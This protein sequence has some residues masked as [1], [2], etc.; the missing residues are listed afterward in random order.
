LQIGAAVVAVGLARGQTPGGKAPATVGK[1]SPNRPGRLSPREAVQDLVRREKLDQ[2][3]RGPSITRTAAN[4]HGVMVIVFDPRVPLD[5]PKDPLRV[6]EGRPGET[7]KENRKVSSQSICGQ[8]TVREGKAVIFTDPPATNLYGE[9]TCGTS[10]T[11]RGDAY[12]P[13]EYR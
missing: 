4:A 5:S 13:V 9:P 3:K 2:G 11:Y 1:E 12:V 6:F 8:I 10:A 7:L